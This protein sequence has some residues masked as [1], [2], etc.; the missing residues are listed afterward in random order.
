M[1][2]GL[3]PGPELSASTLLQGNISSREDPIFVSPYLLL[4]RLGDNVIKPYSML[5]L[6][7]LEFSGAERYRHGRG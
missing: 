4:L 6:D 7:E 1:I 3:I 2:D 5:S